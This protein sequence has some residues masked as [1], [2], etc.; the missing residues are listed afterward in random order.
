MKFTYVYTLE[1][2]NCRN[3]NLFQRA[4]LVAEKAIC[5]ASVGSDKFPTAYGNPVVADNRLIGIFAN[6]IAR[7]VHVIT[8]VSLCLDWISNITGIITSS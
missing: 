6:S 8:P 5:A 1:T 2:E 7:Q 4:R 3:V